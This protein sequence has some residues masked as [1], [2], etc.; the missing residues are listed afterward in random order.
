ML[1]AHV[2]RCHCNA[3]A[4]ADTAWRAEDGRWNGSQSE[5]E[6][7]LAGAVRT[8]RRHPSSSLSGGVTMTT[9]EVMAAEEACGGGSMMM[10][11][12]AAR[13]DAASG[14]QQWQW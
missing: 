12:T 5:R 3:D 1:A 10:T 7:K 13:G 6:S 11:R 14:L 8:R 4:D 2:R 9:R